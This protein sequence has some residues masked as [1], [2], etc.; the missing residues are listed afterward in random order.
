MS[1]K[2]YRNILFTALAV[3]VCSMMFILGGFYHYFDIQQSERLFDDLKMAASGVERFGVGYLEKTD[4]G[5]CR[6]TWLD[7]E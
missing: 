6:V 1:K 5:T 3:F 4:F 7:P 2:I